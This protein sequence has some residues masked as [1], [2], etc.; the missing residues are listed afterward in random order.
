MEVE[1]LRNGVHLMANISKSRL[2]LVSQDGDTE[3]PKWLPEH[4]VG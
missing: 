1:W 2:A 4:H 3:E